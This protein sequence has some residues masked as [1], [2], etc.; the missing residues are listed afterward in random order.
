MAGRV[1]PMRIGG[2]ELLVE[3]TPVAGSEPTSALGRA[4]DAVVGAYER[5]QAAIVAVASSTV[6][7]IGQL[8]DKPARLE[9]VEVK[10]GLKFSAQGTVV[11]AGASGE[12]TLEVTLRY[13]PGAAGGG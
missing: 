12:A 4:Q 6:D 11:L 10:F 2:V 9:Q 3:T 1:M 13:S 8:D 7:V 5:A